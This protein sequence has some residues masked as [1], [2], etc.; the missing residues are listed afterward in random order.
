VELQVLP[1]K[2]CSSVGFSLRGAAGPVGSLLQHMPPSGIHLLWRGVLHGLQVEV[3]FPVG[4]RGTACLNTV[5]SRRCRGTLLRHLEHL[6]LLRWPLCPQSSFT[7]SYSFLP[8]AVARRFF[9]VKH[10]ITEVLP[11]SLMGLALANGSSILE[12]A[13]TGFDLKLLAPSHRSHPCSP[14]ATRTLP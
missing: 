7:Y 3:C 10:V 11:T 9:H 12:L 13:G 2:T 4:C 14:P 1:A 6:L 5:V 8:A